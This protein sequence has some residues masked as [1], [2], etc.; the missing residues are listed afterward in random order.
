M[1]KILHFLG[2]VIVRCIGRL[3]FK[4]LYFLGCAVGE[5]YW[6]TSRRDK[7]ITLVNISI[8]F[9]HLSTK[10]QRIMAKKSMVH[11]A[12]NI[13]E[14]LWVWEHSILTV[15]KKVIAYE[16]LELLKECEHSDKGTLLICGHFG[17]WEVLTSI[18]GTHCEA[19][20]YLGK[21]SGVDLFDNHIKRGRE[22]AGSKL[23][24]TT[25]EGLIQFEQYL[26]QGHLTG[27]LSDQEP[28]LKYGQFAPFFNTPAL[29][30]LLAQNLIQKNTPNVIMGAAIRLPKGRG[31]KVCFFKP[32]DDL[33]SSDINTST[34]ALNAMY[35][36][37]IMLEPNQYIWNYK[38]YRTRPEG[39]PPV[40]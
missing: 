18:L 35:E 26:Q 7:H 13:V 39:E 2:Y 21:L 10:A 6:L 28:S 25:R 23:V 33:L 8:A 38:R 3:P 9:P 37:I 32:D 29:T 12:I 19:P 16:G 22:F 40:Y 1:K 24:N 4:I 31:F 17:S 34:P 27:L 30:S 11:T 5:I 36:R 14:S 15:S 20:V